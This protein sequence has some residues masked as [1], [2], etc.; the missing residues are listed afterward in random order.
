[1]SDS[2]LE[3]I[4]NAHFRKIY[5][6]FYYKILQ[7]ELAEDLTSDTFIRYVEMLQQKQPGEIKDPVKYLYGIAKLVLLKHL[8]EKYNS[9]KYIPIEDE[10][11][12]GAYVDDF[13]EEVDQAKTPEELALSYIEQLPD[14]QKE[15]ITMRLINK[16]SLREI[17]TETGKDMNYVKTTQ[18][19]A[20]RSLKL[21]F[22]AGNCTLT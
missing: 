12:F 21:L 7:R 17:C 4:Y 6:F 5:R 22:A 3:V 10:D 1:M 8:H 16:M 13:L 9:I 18:K 20:L 11:D 15:I 14:K 19:R 2:E